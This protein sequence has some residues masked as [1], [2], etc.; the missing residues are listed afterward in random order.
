M[1]S[2]N[3]KLTVKIILLMIIIPI[4][5]YLF[6]TSFDNNKE[7]LTYTE[8]GT[9]DYKVC[10]KENASFEE[11]CL[12][13]GMSYIANTID[14]INIDFDYSFKMN[15]LMNYDYEYYVE[16]IIVITERGNTNKILQE[17][18][19]ITLKP[20]QKGTKN[21]SNLIEISNEMI[22]INYDEYNDIVKSF[23]HEFNI[24]IESYLKIK[25]HINVNSKYDK[26][27]SPIKTKNVIEL[28]I[29]LTESTVD[30]KMDSKNVNSSKEITDESIE[31]KIDY[32]RISSACILTVVALIILISIVAKAAKKANEMSEYDKFIGNI[33]KNYDRWII[34]AAPTEENKLWEDEYDKTIDVIEFQELVDKADRSGGT[35]LFTE[36][37]NQEG[38]KVAWFTIEDNGRLY[39]KIYTSVDKKFK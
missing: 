23:R 11:E 26:F 20:L 14:Y 8:E 1:K 12:P 17:R 39:R 37:K 30:I 18:K 32:L 13:K 16:G 5:A 6:L 21:N 38:K 33:L 36:D 3:V 19:P 9:I 27:P 15:Q 34:S 29:P 25:L 2:K 7:T 4:S 35:I 31:N 24:P 22:K 28:D 10:L